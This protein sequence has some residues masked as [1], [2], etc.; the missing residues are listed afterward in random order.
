MIRS[1]C[2]GAVG[3]LYSNKVC[4]HIILT[5][6]PNQTLH[7]FSCKMPDAQAI[8]RD[9]VITQIRI[10]CLMWRH[11]T[12]QGKE[13]VRTRTHLR[14]LRNRNKVLELC[15]CQTSAFPGDSP[16]TTDTSSGVPLLF[17]KLTAYQE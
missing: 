1:W 2:T 6:N 11:T 8:V 7:D 9:N 17:G 16:Q 15:Y 13:R 3:W 14:I 4:L 5:Y 10:E 12:I